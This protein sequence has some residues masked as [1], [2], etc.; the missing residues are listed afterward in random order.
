M[1][2]VLDASVTAVW[3]FCDEQQPVADSAFRA[4]DHEQAWVPTLWWYE[5]R[6]ILLVNERRNRI[7]VAESTQFLIDMDNFPIFVD[8]ER[9]PGGLFELA[10]LYS[11]TVHDAAYL[12]LAMRKRVPLATLDKAL[13]LAAEAAG[14]ALLS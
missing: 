7:T 10:R 5:I 3:A 1:A 6:N 2:F 11:L 4:L 13:R 14:V 9:E 12:E 8:E